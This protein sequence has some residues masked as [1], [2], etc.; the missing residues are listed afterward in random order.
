MDMN[1][2]SLDKLIR[3]K[4]REH[5]SLY[6]ARWPAP[7]VLW[8][9]LNERRLLQAKRRNGWWQ[10]AA[11]LLIIMMAG[12]TFFLHNVPGDTIS[13]DHSPA[14]LSIKE[15]DAVDFIARYCAG[16]NTSCNTPAIRELRGDL[17]QSF[18]KLEEIDDQLK[19][20]ENDA[21]LI[22]AKDRIESHQARLIKTIVQI[23]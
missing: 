9:S 23:L 18:R 20:Y 7:D 14:T 3:E 16:K 8:R 13:H 17:E 12:Y 2:D 5:E 10:A 21:E 4:V 19:V 15:Q 11:A 6:P 22:R 1:D